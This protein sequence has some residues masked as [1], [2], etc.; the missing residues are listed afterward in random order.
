MDEI[1]LVSALVIGLSLGV[2]GSGGAILTFPTLLYFL[3]LSEK[4]AIIGSLF[5][6]A[7]IA[8]FTSI[9]HLAKKRVSVKHLVY[10]AIPGLMFSYLGAYVGSLAAS[11]TQILMFV[12]L[13]TLAAVKMLATKSLPS[14]IAGSVKTK[15]TPLIIS[16]GMVGF[17]TGLVGVGGGF[18][19]VPSLFL[20][21]KLSLERAMATSI[22][23]IFLQSSIGFFAYAH[24]SSEIVQDM[25]WGVLMSIAFVGVIGAYLGV[26]IV[27]HIDQARLSKSFGIFLILMSAFLLVD[28][29]YL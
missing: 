27:K 14:S 3:N 20:L 17:A 24:Y 9:P 25:Q 19:I 15:L 8:A 5:I 6:V 22:V 7:I 1:T 21:A 2:F 11:W 13:M 4:A 28:R 10:F 16:G 12:F 23:I 18:L 29:L 26:A